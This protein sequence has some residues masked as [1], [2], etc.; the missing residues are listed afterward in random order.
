MTVSNNFVFLT[1]AST[2]QSSKEFNEYSGSLLQLEVGGT[3]TSFQLKV[4]V[5]FDLNSKN[6]TDLALVNLSRLEVVE[7]VTKKGIYSCSI[8]GAQKVKVVLESVSGGYVNVF[9]RSLAD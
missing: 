8:A 4:Q 6:Y 7:K 1:E 5:Y 9:G 3:A 2:A